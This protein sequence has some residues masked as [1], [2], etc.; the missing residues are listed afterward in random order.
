MDRSNVF[1]GVSQQVVPTKT[2]GFIICTRR[3][4][5]APTGTMKVRE[6]RNAG[7]GV[8][9]GTAR[10]GRIVPGSQARNASSSNK[11]YPPPFT[12]RRASPAPLASG[13][14]PDT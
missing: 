10:G 13:S 2:T 5:P 4:P 14:V 8:R 12:P 9:E 11:A 3:R 1:I 7:G 6:G